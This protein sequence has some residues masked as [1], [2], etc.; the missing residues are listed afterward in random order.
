MTLQPIKHVRVPM[1]V[2]AVVG[3]P[4]ADECH[5]FEEEVLPWR[6]PFGACWPTPTTTLD[7]A[8]STTTPF[9]PPPPF[10]PPSGI[11]PWF[12]CNVFLE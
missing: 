2:Q 4:A 11:S 6:G 5:V 12:C 7:A 3:Y 8:S 10:V 1:R 9:N